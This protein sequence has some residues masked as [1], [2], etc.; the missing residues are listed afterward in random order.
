MTG[1][2]STGRRSLCGIPARIYLDASFIA[3]A[4]FSHTRL[5]SRAS[6]LL[7]RLRTAVAR[8]DSRVLTSTRAV[9]EVLWIARLFV[10]ERDH[11]RGSWAE[12]SPGGRDEAWR[13]YSEEIANLGRILLSPDAP[14][15]VLPVTAEDLGLALSAMESHALQPAD[16]SHY[17][18]ACRACDGCIVTNDRHFRQIGDLHVIRYDASD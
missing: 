10:Y 15:E 9:D 12:L 1:G 3:D 4:L 7:R 17:A 13:R 2:T 14:W 6:A 8:R 16:A 18:V 5:H 11:G